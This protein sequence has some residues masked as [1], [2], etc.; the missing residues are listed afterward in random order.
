MSLHQASTT[1]MRR[2]GRKCFY[3]CGK[4]PAQEA[5][6]TTVSIDPRSAL[7][8][9]REVFDDTDAEYRSNRVASRIDR[10][11]HASHQPNR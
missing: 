5:A 1:T 7:P 3:L 10:I 8:G 6:S 2:S 11:D 9:S 4:C